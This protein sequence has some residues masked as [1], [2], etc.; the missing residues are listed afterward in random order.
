MSTKGENLVVDLDEAWNEA[1]EENNE[2]IA[3]EIDYEEE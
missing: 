1:I 2:M 3:D